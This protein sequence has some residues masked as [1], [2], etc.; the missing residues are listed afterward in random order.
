[1]DK[2]I[3]RE[4]RYSKYSYII[5]FYGIVFIPIMVINFRHGTRGMENLPGYI[6]SGLF[7]FLC[8]VLL[9]TMRTRLKFI[10][11][12]IL[13]MVILTVINFFIWFILCEGT[14]N[15]KERLY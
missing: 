4:S 11:K 2:L 3:G 9:Y 15:Y 12:I 13:F 5:F 6:F 1:M 7:S 14:L 10:A 8:A